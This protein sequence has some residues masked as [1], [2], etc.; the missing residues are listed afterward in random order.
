MNKLKELL[1]RLEQGKY[2]SVVQ[3]VK[4]GLVGVSNTIIDYALQMLCFYV[5]FAGASWP[6]NTKVVVA[7]YVGFFVSVINSYYWNNRFVFKDEER[8]G[9]KRHA[10]AYLKTVLCYGLTG[11]LLGPAL[12]L[13][14]T[15]IDIPYWL[16]S[17]GVLVITIPLNFLLN[18]F[19][20]FRKK[21]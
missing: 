9:F 19:W 7:S 13:W 16:A 10:L 2:A 5:L 4:F 12:K 17:L 8:R 18:K 15:N 21:K 1:S 6:E 11:L 3:F 14:L 20:A